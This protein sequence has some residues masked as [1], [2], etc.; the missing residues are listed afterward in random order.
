MWPL[1][2][3]LPRGSWGLRTGSSGLN[4]PLA[5]WLRARSE[6]WV[7]NEAKIAH[8]FNIITL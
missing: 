3:D 6:F 5:M 1:K 8:C 2:L 4:T 7:A